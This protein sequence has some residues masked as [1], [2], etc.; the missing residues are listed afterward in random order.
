MLVGENGSLDKNLITGGLRGDFGRFL[1]VII[2]T[3]GQ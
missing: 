3:M 2:F 1:P